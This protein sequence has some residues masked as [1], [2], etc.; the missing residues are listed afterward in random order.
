M[1]NQN[2]PQCIAER[3]AKI[4]NANL[5]SIAKYGCCAF[6]L[7]WCLYIEGTEIEEIESL[8]RMILAG[9]IGKDCTVKWEQA[10]E[11]LTGKKSKIEFVK[12]NSIAHIKERTPVRY[13][14]NGKSHWVGVENGKV[15]YN[16]L[17]QSV[18]VELG[19][20]TE[21]RVITLK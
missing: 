15:A 19:K 21:S 20:P 2:H 5:Q 6:V 7:R 12:I 3:L 16:P 4:P 11:F 13:D 8:N 1:Q 14:Y 18:C 17:K 10:I 9:A